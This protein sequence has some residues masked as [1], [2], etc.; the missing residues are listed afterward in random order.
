M[1]PFY[2]G[3]HW[4]PT[5]CAVMVDK[6]SAKL[7]LLSIDWIKLGRELSVIQSSGVSGIQGCLSS[8]VNGRTVGTFRIIR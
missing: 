7:G 1:E 6:R 2:N 8:E 5:L 3:H 4:E